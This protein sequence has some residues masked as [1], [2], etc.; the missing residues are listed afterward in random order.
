MCLVLVSFHLSESQ[1][2]H[3]LSNT[4]THNRQRDAPG[5]SGEKELLT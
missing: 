3:D 4:D 1:D 2:P 5:N